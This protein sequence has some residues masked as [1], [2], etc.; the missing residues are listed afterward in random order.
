MASIN[1]K[2][3]LIHKIINKTHQLTTQELAE[4]N[5]HLANELQ[6]KP[7]WRFKSWG[8]WSESVHEYEEAENRILKLTP[9]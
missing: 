7:G 1:S 4:L 2:L 8:L 3:W 9:L 5:F 6:K